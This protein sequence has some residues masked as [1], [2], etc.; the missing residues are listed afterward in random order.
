[1]VTLNVVATMLELF[2]LLDLGGK[3]FSVIPSDC[4]FAGVSENIGL[5][6]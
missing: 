1:V 3:V 5:A 6:L 4:W 2:S